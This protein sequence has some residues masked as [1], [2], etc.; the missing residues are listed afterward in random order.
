MTLRCEDLAQYGVVL[1]PPISP[2]YDSLLADIRR[3]PGQMAFAPEDRD[4]SAILINRGT[5]PIVAM[6]TAWTCQGSI[7]HTIGPSAP[8][9]LLPFE[10][11][12]EE[13]AI[14]RYWN[15]ILPGSKRYLTAQ[16]QIGNNT[17]VRP[18]HANEDWTGGTWSGIIGQASSRPVSGDTTLKIDGVFFADGAFA[19]PDRLG[20]WEDVLVVA[21]SHLDVARLA[22]E[23]HDKGVPA[24]QILAS[25]EDVVR[26]F[27]GSSFNR[28]RRVRAMRQV[29]ARVDAHRKSQGDD[30]AVY[31]LMDW[32][33]AGVPKFRRLP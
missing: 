6:A 5:Q 4:G 13:L 21:Q 9:S 14:D 31:A 8:K 16:G 17:D 10:V 33:S 20:L 29:A 24:V 23:G 27:R 32:A 28:D 25:I 15:T 26:P 12:A 2:Q 3:R 30:K 1:I 7:T 18:P 22:R 11:P 19:G